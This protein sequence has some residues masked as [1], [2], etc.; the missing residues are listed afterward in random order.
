[1]PS[2]I[3]ACVFDAYGTLF[4]V[5]SA[6]RRFAAQIGPDAADFSQLWR[7][8][9]LEYSWVRSLARRH[10]DFRQV[11]IEALE[12]SMRYFS[13]NNKKLG[14]DLIAVYR[15][16]EVYPEVIPGLQQLRTSGVR[17]AILS[18]GTPDWLESAV[19]SAGIAELFD[20]VWSV[21]DV[22]IFKP[23]P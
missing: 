23:D 4:D 21:E 2:A 20:F 11:T 16:L 14:D 6:V 5:H 18:N 17:L 13:I 12:F 10:V 9:Q 22:G 8:K 1:M 19:R 3:R 15:E 7:T